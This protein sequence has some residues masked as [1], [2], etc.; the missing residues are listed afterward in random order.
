ME[1][2]IGK[3]ILFIPGTKTDYYI[4][5]EETNEIKVIIDSRE[6]LT[7]LSSG[8]ELKRKAFEEFKRRNNLDV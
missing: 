4:S 5:P 6:H 1:Y 2:Q 3:E 7:D 8:E